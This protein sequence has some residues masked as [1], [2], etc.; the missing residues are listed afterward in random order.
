MVPSILSHIVGLLKGVIPR[1]AVGFV[2]PRLC[3][4]L[5]VATLQVDVL[6]GCLSYSRGTP[7]PSV[8]QLGSFDTYMCCHTCTG[9]FTVIADYFML[10]P[11]LIVYDAYGI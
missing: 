3:R 10:Y 4:I 1:C 8:A 5:P 9:L 7:C 2:I 11:L 6:P